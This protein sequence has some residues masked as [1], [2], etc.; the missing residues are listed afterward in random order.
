MPAT[1]M[2]FLFSLIS[3]ELFERSFI[4]WREILAE[5]GIY[6]ERGEDK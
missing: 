6:P 4:D 1:G 2:S 5:Q 3:A